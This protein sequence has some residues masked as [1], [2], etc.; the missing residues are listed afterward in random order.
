MHTIE[1]ADA[2]M[3]THAHSQMQCHERHSTEAQGL[4]QRTHAAAP[5]TFILPVT[6][7]ACCVVL[8]ALAGRDSWRRPL[9]VHSI[10]AHG[11]GLAALEGGLSACT[12]ACARMHIA[13]LRARTGAC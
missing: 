12:R 6:I 4:Q 10:V 11:V 3:P 9:V 2:H 8:G 5:P 1:M 13:C 7:V